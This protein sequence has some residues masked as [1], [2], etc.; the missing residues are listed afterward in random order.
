MDK[1]LSLDGVHFSYGEGDPVV[2]A[3]LS[4][5]IPAGKVTAILGP[6]G[7]GKTT[8]LHI[9]LGLLKPFQ[10]VVT[11]AGKPHKGYSKRE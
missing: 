1:I 7:T 6:N 10:G 5:K 3:D 2:L 8:M 9:M 11:V 4:L